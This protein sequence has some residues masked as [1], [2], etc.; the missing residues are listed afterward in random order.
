MQIEIYNDT[1][2]LHQFGAAYWH[3]QKM[4]LVADVHFGK[5]AHFRKY[6]SALPKKAII[7]NFERL[8]ELI[9]NFKPKQTCFLGDLFHSSFNSEWFYFEDWVKRHICQFTLVVGNHDIISPTKFES[10]G[11]L[12]H[13]EMIIDSFLLTH[14]PK[15]QDSYFNFCG[16]IHPG[17][18][19]AGQARQT[20]KLPCFLKKPNQL[21][22]PAFGEFTGNYIVQPEDDNQIFVITP[23]EVVLIE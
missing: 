2:T 16:H 17:V 13:E 6:G 10:L 5:I 15:E 19:L 14:H 4:L 7:R 11:F 1:F 21:I 3:E 23:E 22:F 8:D 12:I 9:Q 20:L 18:K